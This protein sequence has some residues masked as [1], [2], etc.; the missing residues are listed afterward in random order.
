MTTKIPGTF[1]GKVK[2]D[3]SRVRL[4]G[5]GA[6]IV[7]GA[8]ALF[9]LFADIHLVP[10]LVVPLAGLILLLWGAGIRNNGLLVAGGVLLGVGVGLALTETVLATSSD[11]TQTGVLLIC[12]ALGWLLVT[13]LSFFFGRKRIWWPVVPGVACLVA[14]IGML[15][16]TNALVGEIGRFWP[17]LLIT[18]GIVIIIL[19]RR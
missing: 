15:F 2:V 16:N 14:G 3:H 1:D 12:F 8:F 19:R 7:V 6:L 11:S 18:A 10:L 17:I 5:G 9:S 13:L 4:I